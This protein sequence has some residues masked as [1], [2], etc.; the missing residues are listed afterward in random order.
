MVVILRTAL[1]LAPAPSVT[2]LS[3]PE[4]RR[5]LLPAH[6]TEVTACYL[7]R[8]P[9]SVCN[10]DARFDCRSTNPSSTLLTIVLQL[11]THLNESQNQ[12][13]QLPSPIFTILSQL[14]A[15]DSRSYHTILSPPRI[16]TRSTSITASFREPKSL[17]EARADDSLTNSGR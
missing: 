9:V 2:A 8:T 10:A 11:C 1:V 12:Q 17:R 15:H 4:A 14:R 16:M 6:S 3:S 13:P 7:H 5:D